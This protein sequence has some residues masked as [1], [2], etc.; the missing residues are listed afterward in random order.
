MSRNEAEGLRPAP[1][2]GI[3]LARARSF[4]Q[5]ADQIPHGRFDSNGIVPVR[6]TDGPY[7]HMTEVWSA[8]L[9]EFDPESHRLKLT[10]S[11]AI[12]V[13]AISDPEKSVLEID[14]SEVRRVARDEIS[15][16]GVAKGIDVQVVTFEP[17]VVG[18]REA[19]KIDSQTGQLMDRWVL[20]A[21]EQGAV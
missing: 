11:G 1:L 8:E 4:L 21:V 13:H 7:I 2:T 12:Q 19:V 20:S 5:N 6:Y 16:S 15:P 17:W 10:E 18:P 9:L 3:E 14:P